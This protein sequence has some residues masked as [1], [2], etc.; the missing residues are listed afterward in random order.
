MESHPELEK[1]T[2]HD[3]MLMLEKGACPMLRGRSLHLMTK[4]MMIDHLVKSKCPELAKIMRIR[5][6]STPSSESGGESPN[7]K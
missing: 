7:H 6:P 2:K 1:M 5:R 4:Q 3:L